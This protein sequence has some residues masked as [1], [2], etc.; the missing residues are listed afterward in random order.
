MKKIMFMIITILNICLVS[1]QIDK[2]PLADKLM[3]NISGKVTYGA[4]DF[5]K[6]KFGYVGE[7]SVSWFLLNSGKNAFGVRGFGG[8]GLVKGKDYYPFPATPAE[9]ETKFYYFGGG[10]VYSYALYKK[11]HPFINLGIE[12]LQFDPKDVNGNKMPGN[13]AGIYKKNDIY[14]NAE[15]GFNLMLD[16]DLSLMVSGGGHYAKND[17]LDDVKNGIHGDWIYNAGIGLSY[18]LFGK[19]EEEPIIPKGISGSDTDKDKDGVPDYMDLCPNTQEGS[20]VDSKGCAVDSDGDGV[21]DGID[22]CADTPEGVNVDTKGCPL[23]SDKDG[24]ADYLDKCPDT[25]EGKE[26]DE[27][28]CEKGNSK[29]IKNENS[30]EYDFKNETKIDDNIFTDGKMFCFQVSSW[31]EESKAVKQTEKLLKKKH[32]AFIHKT[33]VEGE[34]GVW[35]RVRIGYYKTEKEARDYLRKHFISEKLGNGKKY[36]RTK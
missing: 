11:F 1:G 30:G 26:V 18:S 17:Y 7:A 32:K 10:I 14:F 33:N 9:Y 20:K 23:D 19:G 21:P 25:P 22:E 13:Q 3:F 24:V 28:G 16:D 31:N 4:T 12:Y 29:E 34:P 36:Y 8:Y 15:L 27:N 6:S 35:Y 2:H 5:V